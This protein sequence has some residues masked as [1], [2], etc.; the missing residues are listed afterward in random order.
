[1]IGGFLNKNLFLK[2]RKLINHKKKISLNGRSS[3]SIILKYKGI[4]KLLIPYYICDVVLDTLSKLGIKYKFYKL[5]SNLKP[6]YDDFKK[7]Q[8]YSVL[9]LP[10]FGVI[11]LK[12]LKNC[13][14]DLSTSFFYP[15]DNIYY[16]DSIRKFFFVNLG[17]NLNQEA[18]TTFHQPKNKQLTFKVPRR[19]S[20]F[21]NNEKRHVISNYNYAKKISKDYFFID[22]KKVKE[23][24]E[25][26]F[27][28]FFNQLS[29]TNKIKI[30]INQVCGPLYYPYLCDG[31]NLLRE[32]LINQ[33]IFVPRYWSEILKRT[34]ISSFRFEKYLCKNLVLL[35]VD[36]RLNITNLK[37][38]LEKLKKFDK[39]TFP[40]C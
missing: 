8:E 22:F 18:F 16:F 35:P 29:S 24:R 11:K 17:S 13:I 12:K 38:I 3:L 32:Y 2:K 23:K 15:K 33:K 31:G 34:D 28:F 7:N 1:M 6:N 27:L 26:N 21:L 20:E 40:I 14:F 9:L 36:E 10:Y 39:K 19:Y 25:K 4:K 5:N 30:S 37:A